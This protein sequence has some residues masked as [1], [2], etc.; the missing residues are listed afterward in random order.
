MP[1]GPKTFVSSSQPM[2]AVVGENTAGGDGVF[3]IGHALTG[4]GV[5]RPVSIHPLRVCDPPA[6][7]AKDFVECNRR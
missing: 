6:S 3:G 2:A 4:R 5:V 7:T 1:D